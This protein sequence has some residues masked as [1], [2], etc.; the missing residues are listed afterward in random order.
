MDLKASHRDDG[1]LIVMGPV[2]LMQ[3][4]QPVDAFNPINPSAPVQVVP[5]DSKGDGEA[6]LDGPVSTDKAPISRTFLVVA[7]AVAVVCG[8]GGT[9]D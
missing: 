1:F 9:C 8:V 7:L 2:Y 4:V 3:V 5:D 6:D